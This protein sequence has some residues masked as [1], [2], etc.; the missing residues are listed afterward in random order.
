MNKNQTNGPQFLNMEESVQWRESVSDP[1]TRCLLLCAEATFVSRVLTGKSFPVED[2]DLFLLTKVMKHFCGQ[3]RAVCRVLENKG[4]QLADSFLKC[5]P[6]PELV[7]EEEAKWVILNENDPITLE[8]MK[9]AYK[10]LCETILKEKPE[11]N[12]RFDA[13]FFIDIVHDFCE[14][15]ED[16][17]TVIDGR[18][19]DLFLFDD[20]RQT[21]G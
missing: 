12:I 18:G 3:H 5:D 1:I 11:P 6:L 21:F 15:H 9:M 16:F 4:P 7:R 20:R 19:A 10:S 8:L 13:K 14:R 2:F 17:R